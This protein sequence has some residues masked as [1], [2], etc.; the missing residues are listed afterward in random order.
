MLRICLHRKKVIYT[1][2]A[3]FQIALQS[4]GCVPSLQTISSVQCC[5]NLLESAK[6]LSFFSWCMF[7]T[8]IFK[9]INVELCIRVHWCFCP[10]ESVFLCSKKHTKSLYFFHISKSLEF[11]QTV[12]KLFQWY[13]R[14][15]SV[16]LSLS[17]TDKENCYMFNVTCSNKYIGNYQY[18]L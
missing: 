1:L 10:Y 8:V 2:N 12:H 5:I 17:R 4:T 11:E 13:V 3:I 16:S 6:L 9:R 7:L 18:F 15:L 14:K